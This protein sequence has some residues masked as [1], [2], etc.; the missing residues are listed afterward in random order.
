[1]NSSVIL[2]G[3]SAGFAILAV[4]SGDA[5]AQTTY[6]TPSTTTQPQREHGNTSADDAKAKEIVDKLYS[7]AQ[8]DLAG[9]HYGEAAKAYD[10]AV[11]VLEKLYGANDAR[12]V[13]ALNGVIQ[14]RMAWDNYIAVTGA[15]NSAG[16]SNVVKA[17]EHI[18]KIDE[19]EGVDPKARIAATIDLGDVYLYANDKRAIDTYK[20]AWQQQAKLDSPQSADALFG[21]VALVRLHLPANPLGHQEWTATVRYDVSADGRATVSDVSGTAPESL[22]SAISKSYSEAGFRPRFAAGE[23]VTTTGISSTHKYVATDRQQN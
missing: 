14:T 6:Q 12:L 3:V 17:Q 21:S 20:D 4:V 18:V 2:C 9:H 23:P 22:T 19:Q 15:S 8:A 16:L 1:M 5:F 7:A 11:R 13:P 10:E